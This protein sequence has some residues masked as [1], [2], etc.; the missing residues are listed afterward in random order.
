MKPSSS[1]RNFTPNSTAS[2]SG[3]A[4]TA[5]VAVLGQIVHGQVAADAVRTLAPNGTRLMTTAVITAR[6]KIVD[7]RPRLSP[8][9]RAGPADVR[10]CCG[11]P[12]VGRREDDVHPVV[13]RVVGRGREA[14]TGPVPIDTIAAIDSVGQCV[15]RSVVRA[16]GGEIVFVD[17]IP[18]D[19]A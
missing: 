8:G 16:G 17:G 4:A 3:S 11:S 19:G 6:M 1:A 15:Q 18:S 13:A 14:A 10:T 5:G 2:V 9:T 12:S 7:R